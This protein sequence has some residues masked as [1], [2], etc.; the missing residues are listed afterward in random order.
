MTILSKILV[1]NKP[2]SEQNCI[3]CS[4]S[5]RVKTSSISVGTQIFCFFVVFGIFASFMD[6]ITDRDNISFTLLIICSILAI[7]T[8]REY[9][10]QVS[11]AK[12]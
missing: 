7:V 8:L 6:V 3:T 5:G 10:Q 1:F 2:I 11:N 4:G 12:S 9:K